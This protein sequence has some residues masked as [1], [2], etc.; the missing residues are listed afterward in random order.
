M[1]ISGA[2]WGASW[3]LRTSSCVLGK[4]FTVISIFSNAQPLRD[5]RP[6]G[7]G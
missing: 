5:E 2:K 1:M 3:A 6:T 4:N 7:Q